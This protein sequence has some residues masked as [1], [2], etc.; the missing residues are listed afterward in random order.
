[1]IRIRYSENARVFNTHRKQSY[2]VALGDFQ[3]VSYDGF[4]HPRRIEEARKEIA[5]HREW[6]VDR[7]HNDPDGRQ[8]QRRD[9]PKTNE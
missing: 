7:G 8:Q 4:V 1:M 9:E 5:Q 3:P 6:N 2:F